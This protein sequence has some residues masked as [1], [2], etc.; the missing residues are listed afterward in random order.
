MKKTSP[1]KQFNWQQG[2]LMLGFMAI[3]GACGFLIIRY[4]EMTSGA[5]TSAVKELLA[6]SILLLAM[7]A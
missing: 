7:Y 6:F 1:K 3:G 4:M 5:D 2:L